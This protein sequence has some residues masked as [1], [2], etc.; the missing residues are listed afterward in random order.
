M[1]VH[2]YYYNIEGAL[3]VS[4]TH[5]SYTSWLKYFFNSE[6]ALSKRT[7]NVTSTTKQFEKNAAN[8]GEKYLMS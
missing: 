6:T 8:L 4:K 3:I 7:A 2:K 5:Y 1:F